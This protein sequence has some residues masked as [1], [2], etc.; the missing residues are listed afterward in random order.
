MYVGGGGLF[1][2]EIINNRLV[3]VQGTAIVV[4]LPFQRGTADEALRHAAWLVAMAEPLASVAFDDV[5]R[6]VENT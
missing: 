2:M 1:K 5:R 6:A 3:G 4:M